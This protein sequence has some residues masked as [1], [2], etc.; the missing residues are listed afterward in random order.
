MVPTSY[1][2]CYW[3]WLWTILFLFN[4]TK[5]SPLPASIGALIYT[6][7]SV[8][9]SSWSKKFPPN[10]KYF[11]TLLELIVVLSLLYKVKKPIK[12]FFDNL[13]VNILVFIVY[14]GYIFTQ[15]KTFTEIYFHDVPNQ[16]E[17]KNGINNYMNKRV[18][19]ISS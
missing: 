15:N 11:I 10:F 2:F 13:Y 12:S 19:T 3:I 18:Q 17:F 4:I 16:K 5:Y 8:F 14:L 7:W 9:F 1:I 6:A